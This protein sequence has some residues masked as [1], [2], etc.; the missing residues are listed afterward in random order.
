VQIWVWIDLA[1]LQ[2]TKL[3]NLARDS[4]EWLRTSSTPWLEDFQDRSVDWHKMPLEN[5]ILV[6]DSETWLNKELGEEWMP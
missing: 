5:W 6:T 4:V 1:S 2:E 3:N